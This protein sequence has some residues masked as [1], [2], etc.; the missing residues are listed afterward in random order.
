MKIKKVG[1]VGCGLMGSGVALVCA[2]SGYQVIASEINSELLNEGLFT[3]GQFLA[4]SVEKGKLSQEDK[5][6]IL[7][8]IKGTTNLS[9]FADCDLVIEAII[10]NMELKKKIFAELDKICRKDAILAT[11]TSSM[12]VVEIASATNR[13][14]KVLG[15]HFFNP[16]PIM[17]L[18]EI[19]TT[20][21]T[22]E[23]TLK[24]GKEFG[25]SLGKTVVIAKDTPGFIVNRLLT[26]FTLNAMRMLESGIAT[27]DDIDS[28][29]KLGLNH[30]MG[31]LEL[32]DLIGLDTIYNSAS[33]R[34]E[35]LRDPQ[36][37]PP[38]ILKRMIGAGWFGRKVGKGFYEWDS[39]GQ[40]K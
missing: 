11:N 31:P 22:S 17:K 37:I 18:M 5:E 24:I 3:I 28:A 13:L 30:P 40:K 14:D 26:P 23:E 20:I 29:V 36:L 34:Y 38:I 7:S 33:A 32:A 39:K 1:V 35:E 10:E 6:T 16:A 2:R 4:G 21:A 12:C 15:L 9:E 25:E 27:R 8:R 19:V